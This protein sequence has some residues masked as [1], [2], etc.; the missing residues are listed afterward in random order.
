MRLL[1]PDRGSSWCGEAHASAINMVIRFLRLNE[2]NTSAWK[3]FT[4]GGVHRLNFDLHKWV[5]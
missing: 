5:F 3:K 1:V 2:S 4:R